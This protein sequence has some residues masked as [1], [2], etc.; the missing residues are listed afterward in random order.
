MYSREETIKK[1]NEV[2]LRLTQENAQSRR[3]VE[4]AEAIIRREAPNA[5]GL[6]LIGAIKVILKDRNIARNRIGI[7]RDE[8]KK[9]LRLLAEGQPKEAAREANQFLFN[10]HL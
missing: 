6:T 5:D 2:I 7:F 10:N 1:L 8:L 4:E 3:R 9:V